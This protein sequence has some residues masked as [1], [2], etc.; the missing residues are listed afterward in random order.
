[1]VVI[2]SLYSGEPEKIKNKNKPIKEI[3]NRAKNIFKEGEKEKTP[4]LFFTIG[5]S[6][7]P[8]IFFYPR[9]FD[10]LKPI[11]NLS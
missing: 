6:G 9:E 10:F 3:R 1:M 7:N 5:E 2:L 8:I 4:P 11:Y